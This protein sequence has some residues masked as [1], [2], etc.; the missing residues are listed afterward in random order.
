MPSTVI[1]GSG[2]IGLST[3]YYLARLTETDT[4]I[5]PKPTDSQNASTSAASPSETH[6]IH[7]VEPSPELFASASGNAAGFLAK[8]WFATT[9]APLGEF[10]FDLHRKL[11]EEHGG[12][13]KW[14]WSESV[15]YSLDREDSE[16]EAS[17]TDDRESDW[18]EDELG[19]DAPDAA[20][21]SHSP[22]LP[23]GPSKNNLDWLMSGSSR[24]T[25]LRRQ[26]EAGA[27]ALHAAAVQADPDAEPG[28]DLDDD[29]DY[30]RWIRAKRTSMQAISDRSTTG[31]VCVSFSWRVLSLPRMLL[32][33]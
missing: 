10:S 13:E 4:D 8:D 24:A 33:S 14:G 1:L 32:P 23:R 20:S 11:A 2:I 7:L 3:A 22:R 15:S 30:P 26:S 9:V 29:E 18:E 17:E 31:Q 12:R 5:T 16:S 6:E 19:D 25:L 27:A 21:S 28:V